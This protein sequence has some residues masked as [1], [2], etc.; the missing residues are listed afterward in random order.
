MG[1]GMRT[2]LLPNYFNTFDTTPAPTV[3][4]PSRIAKRS[5]CSSATGVMGFADDIYI[6][7]G[8]D[9]LGALGQRHDAGN[10]SRAQIKLRTIVA[11]KNGV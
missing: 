1:P 4:P 10:V 7:A 3:R 9:H 11:L 6:V 8:H 5:P 2:S